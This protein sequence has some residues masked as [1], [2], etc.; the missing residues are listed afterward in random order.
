MKSCWKPGAASLPPFQ[1]KP[2]SST[3]NS[4]AST[5]AATSSRSPTPG[6]ARRVAHGPAVTRPP[7]WPVRSRE[8]IADGRGLS[9][10]GCPP[11]MTLLTIL[12]LA[13]I[14]YVPGAVLFRAPVLDPARRAMLPA[15]ERAF[16]AVLISVALACMLTVALAAADLVYLRAAARDRSRHRRRRDRAVA[17]GAALQGAG[18]ARRARRRSFRWLWSPTGLWL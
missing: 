8:R 13:L 17:R 14:V 15:E 6:I 5:I 18:G 12:Q 11:R 9:R 10:R 7:G 2:A 1:R 3:A 16:W 4:P